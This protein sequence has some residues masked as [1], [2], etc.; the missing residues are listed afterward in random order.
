MGHDVK[1][2]PG[3]IFLDKR[4]LRYSNYTPHNFILVDERGRH[5]LAIYNFTW[6]V[7]AGDM[8]RQTKKLPKPSISP[9]LTHNYDIP[10][11]HLR[12]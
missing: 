2:M 9:F 3:R 1:I 4:S 6:P 10:V 12:L 11:Y 8:V 7:T 5:K